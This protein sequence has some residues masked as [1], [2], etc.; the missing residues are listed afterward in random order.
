MAQVSES[1]A[2][3]LAL[4]ELTPFSFA[5][6]PKV[7]LARPLAARRISR[8]RRPR[9]EPFPAV[10]AGLSRPARATRSARLGAARE[11]AG[12][13]SAAPDDRRGKRAGVERV[14]DRPE[15]RPLLPHGQQLPRLPRGRLPD[16]A[17]TAVPREPRQ[18]TGARAPRSTGATAGCSTR[19]SAGSSEAA[20]LDQPWVGASWEGFVIEQMLAPSR[21]AGPA[22]PSPTS[23]AR[24]TGRSW[25]SS[26]D[27]GDEL[28]AIEVKLTASPDPDDMRRLKRAADLIGAHKAGPAFA[29]A[30]VHG[31]RTRGLVQSGVVRSSPVC[32]SSRRPGRVGRHGL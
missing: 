9:R 32:R 20:L 15:P 29:H 17:A 12:D 3:R 6:V 13:A 23:F 14:P 1:L 5:E 16:P 11:A 7:P 19:C 30:R 31:G 8:R 27:F 26:C 28:W 25:T 2:G 18:A 21:A 10:A 24:A 4:V 22:V